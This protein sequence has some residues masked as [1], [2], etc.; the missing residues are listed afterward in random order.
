VLLFLA[1]AIH[2]HFAQPH[3]KEVLAACVAGAKA[4]ITRSYDQSDEEYADSLDGPI[5]ACMRSKGYYYFPAQ[6]S[7]DGSHMDPACYA[8]RNS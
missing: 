1:L 8:V 4:G 7:C 3:T 2:K 5:A 6:P